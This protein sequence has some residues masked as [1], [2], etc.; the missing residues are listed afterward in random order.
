MDAYRGDVTFRMEGDV[1]VWDPVTGDISKPEVVRTGGGSTTL[2]LDIAPAENIF[3][4]F[5]RKPLDVS[6]ASAAMP[7]ETDFR[8]LRNLR[9]WMISFPSGWGAPQS[10]SLNRLASWTELP[11]S[12]EGRHFSGTATYRTKFDGTRGET[13]VLDLGEV[14]FVADALW[15]LPQ[16]LQC[17]A[18]VAS[19]Q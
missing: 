16:P 2:R 3:V 9:N 5:S 4:V 10:I 18:S 8:D 1:S 13:V 14:E 19:R 6:T 17:S 11:I 15:R 12:K 7:T